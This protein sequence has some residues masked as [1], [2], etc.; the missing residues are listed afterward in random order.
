MAMQP[1]TR[2]MAHCICWVI[3]QTTSLPWLWAAA[4]LTSA[5]LHCKIL[6]ALNLHIF[7]N[8]TFNNTSN[9]QM[10]KDVYIGNIYKPQA[11]YLIFKWQH[12]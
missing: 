10:S 5:A 9:V 12:A 4:P 2:M 11:G 8:A 3:S 7:Y 6:P 1:F